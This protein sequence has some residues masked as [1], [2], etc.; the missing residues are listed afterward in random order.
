MILF[1][2]NF[3]Y[4]FPV[5]MVHTKVTSCNFK[6]SILKK[7]LK[8]NIVMIVANGIVARVTFGTEGY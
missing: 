3:L 6:I 4:A 8:F 7:R 5:T 1:Q 2:P